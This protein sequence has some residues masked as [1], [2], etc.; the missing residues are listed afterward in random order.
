MPSL[1][2]CPT[3]VMHNLPVHGTGG[4]VDLRGAL[5]RWS[6]SKFFCCAQVLRLAFCN[7]IVDRVRLDWSCFS[8]LVDSSRGASGNLLGVTERRRLYRPSKIAR[9]T[10]HINGGDSGFANNFDS[11]KN[12]WA[13]W[14]AWLHS[15]TYLAHT[16]MC[17]NSISH[18]FARLLSSVCFW[19]G[20]TLARRIARTDI[21]LKLKTCVVFIIICRS[22]TY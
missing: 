22:T 16:S 10:I 5:C 11:S 21:V 2:G 13:Q 6:A 7:S 15:H 19:A 1:T 17:L 8:R 4:L 18:I 14:L 9:R 20:H 12:C 3:D